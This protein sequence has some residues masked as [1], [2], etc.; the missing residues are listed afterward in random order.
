MPRRITVFCGSNSG[1][2]PIYA[3]Q[4]REMGRSLAERGWELVYGGGRV[5]L[6]GVV[7]DAC[8]AAGGRVIGVIPQLLA[9]LEVAHPGLTELRIVRSMHERKAMM[10][11]LSDG[12]IALPGGYGTWDELFEALT[13]TQLGIQSKPCGLLNVHGYYD[14]LIAMLDGAVTA[15]F[16]RERHRALLVC[17][18]EV[19]LLLDRFAGG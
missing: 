18:R 14:A 15:G 8:L 13:W 5:G 9:D 2:D 6:M 7:A 19:A 3:D 12:F 11:D 4:A 1:L 16:I 10:A 17:D